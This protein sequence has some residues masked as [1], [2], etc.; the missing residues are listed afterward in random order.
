MPPNVFD[1]VPRLL[2]IP[3][4]RVTPPIVLLVVEALDIV[5]F[6]RIL[7]FALL[8]SELDSVHPPIVLDVAAVLEIV[9][10]LN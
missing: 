1:D 9:P 6:E 4:D 3:P 8:S 7:A 2:I 10:P 5:P